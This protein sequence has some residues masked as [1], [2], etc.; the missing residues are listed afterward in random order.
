ML[1]LITIYFDQVHENADAGIY[2]VYFCDPIF[3]NWSL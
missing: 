2:L 1:V 3:D